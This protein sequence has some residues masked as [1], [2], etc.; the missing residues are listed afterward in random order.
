MSPSHL[1]DLA[2]KTAET[3]KLVLQLSRLVAHNNKMIDHLIKM[4]D[5][6]NQLFERLFERIR[7][8]EEKS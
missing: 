2:E 5:V 1:A 3:S 8:L 7:A 4:G 6:N